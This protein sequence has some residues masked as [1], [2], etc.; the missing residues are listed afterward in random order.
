M[1]ACP[2]GKKAD[3]TTKSFLSALEKGKLNEGK[4]KEASPFGTSFKNEGSFDVIA[5]WREERGGV[6]QRRWR[7][8]T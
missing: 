6:H 7:E 2:L 1:D 8:V 5:N 3:F 4:V